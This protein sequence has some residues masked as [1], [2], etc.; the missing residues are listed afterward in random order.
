MS[1]RENPLGQGVF[2]AGACF[3][4]IGKYGATLK[5]Q[6]DNFPQALGKAI[7]MGIQPQRPASWAEAFRQLEQFLES[8]IL[9]KEK[10]K[11]IVFFVDVSEPIGFLYF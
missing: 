7:G 11:R 8:P 2:Y 10:G 3:E 9:K 6:L 1:C 5:E 4:I